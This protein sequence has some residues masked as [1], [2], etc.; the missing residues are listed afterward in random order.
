[1]NKLEEIEFYRST[2]LAEW[3]RICLSDFFTRFYCNLTPPQFGDLFTPPI[4][5]FDSVCLIS[6][7]FITPLFFPYL[8]PLPPKLSWFPSVFSLFSPPLFFLSICLFLSPLGIL[9]FSLVASHFF[10]P[11][12]S[13]ETRLPFRYWG[14]YQ[15]LCP[16]LHNISTPSCWKARNFSDSYGLYFVIFPS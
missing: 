16:R 10:P 15:E 11:L 9:F 12:Y 8:I 2:K 7:Y 4:V 13:R 6:F 1:M 5:I 14:P 3:P